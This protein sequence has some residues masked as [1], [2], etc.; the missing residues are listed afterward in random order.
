MET[1]TPHWRT[2][3]LSAAFG[4]ACVITT[5]A[6]LNVFGSSMP[7]APAG[8]RITIPLPQ[9]ANLVP[10]SGVQIA[11]VKI[12][13]VI[14]VSRAGNHAQATIELQT[15]YAPLRSGATAI[16]RTKTLLGEGY[17]E[18]APGSQSAAPIADGGR[19]AA[20]N[21]RPSVQLDEFLS[22]FGPGTRARV[23]GLFTGLAGA[24][25]GQAGSLND[26]L[27]FAA[28][29]SGNL[30]LALNAVD[31][32][33]A[34]LKT[35]ISSSADLLSAVGARQGALQAAVSSGNQ[36]LD[37]TARRNQALA[38]TIRALPA[39]LNQLRATSDVI[40]A[41][42][43][44]LNGAVQALQPIAPLL[45]PALQTIDSAAPEFRGLFA[46]LPATLAAG[47][48]GLPALTGI[49]G[50]ARSAFKQFYPTAR[51]LIPFM[52]LMGVNK[53]IIDILANVGSVTSG[54]YVGPG[55]VVLGYA[56]GLPTIWNET[57]S[58]WTHKLPTNRQNPYPAPPNGLLDTGRL[59]VLKSYDCRNTGN[60]LWLP[61][62]GTGAPPCILQGPWSFN[63]KSAYYPRLTLAPP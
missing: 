8:Y 45:P 59:G 48:A 37:A 58:G 7:F 11:G 31:S 28:R 2:W 30:D 41:A 42:S 5:G 52:Q 10:G 62:I 53:N 15:G 19:L 16:A 39:F 49:I 55:G 14:D 9:A 38:A 63:G 60:P 54:S 22:T 57:I 3:I 50:A 61:P 40:T 56:S 33:R 35:L 6:M 32:Q 23:R 29:F 44:D 34:D 17:I 51:E 25:A 21:V 26:S 18:L 4:L 46:E 36:V 1:R 27:G 47:K 43:P 24:L 13:K 12:G 20:A